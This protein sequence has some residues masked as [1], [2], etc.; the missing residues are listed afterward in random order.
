MQDLRSAKGSVVTT[1]RTGPHRDTQGYSINVRICEG[2]L[3]N[4]GTK[5]IFK[6]TCFTKCLGLPVV[7]QGCWWGGE[8]W[9][10]CR[11]GWCILDSKDFHCLPCDSSSM[12][13]HKNVHMYVYI[14]IYIHIYI[15]AYMHVNR[16]LHTYNLLLVFGPC[17]RPTTRRSGSLAVQWVGKEGKT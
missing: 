17:H 15:Y 13:T 6:E 4:T 8:T 12:Y 2:L 16:S 7:C 14:Y 5:G 11:F 1:R 3:G 10:F 9:P